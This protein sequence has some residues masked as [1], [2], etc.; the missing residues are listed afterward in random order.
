M[1]TL[2][3][4]GAGAD[5]LGEIFRRMGESGRTRQVLLVPEQISHECERA[6]CRILGN[7]ASA[8]CE[9]L[10]FTRLGRRV[11]DA[12]GGGAAKTLDAGGR[13]LLMYAALQKVAEELTVYRTPSRKPAFLSGLLETADECKSYA[14]TPDALCRAGEE[15]GGEEGAKCRDLGLIFGAYDAL[16]SRV[17]ADPRD[18]LDRL[19]E[20]LERSRWA[21]GRDFWIYGF[22]DFTPQE[23]GVLRRVLE[24]AASV[25]AALVCDGREDPSGVF[26]AARRS[27]AYLKRLCQQAGTD[28]E[29]QTL[30]PAAGREESL[31]YLEENLFASE[32]EPYAGPCAVTLVTAGDERSEAEWAAAEIL[33]L[34]R[35]EGYRFRDCAVARRPFDGSADLFESVFRKYGVPVFLNNV[36]DILQKP[37]LALVTGALDAAAG[38]YAY[39]D[40]FRYLKTGLTALAPEEC[41]KLENYVLTWDIRG[42]KWNREWTMH[43]EGYGKEFR[44]GDEEKLAELNSLREKVMAPLELL[45]KNETRTGRGDAMALY[46]FLEDIGLPDRL[47]GRTGELT[48][49][50][51]LK[52]AAEYSQLWDILCNALEQCALLLEDAPLDME[53]F[54]RLFSLV[55]SQYDVG[56]IPVSLDRVTAGDAA[57]MGGTRPKVLFFLGADSGNVPQA[58]AA[59][60]LLTDLDRELLSLQDLEL[61]PRLADKMNREMTILYEACS[62][63][64][65]RL[66]MSWAGGTGSQGEEKTP[67]FLVE[68][69]D[70]LF[71]EAERV[72]E[73]ALDGAYRL[74]APGPALEQ[75]GRYPEAA[76]ALGKLP[77]YAPRASRALGAREFRRGRLSPASVR[78]LFGEKVPMSAT[79]LDLY[80]SCHFSHFL[81]FGLGAKPREKARFQASD[82]G[83][84]VHAVLETVLRGASGEENGLR[85]LAED[86][87]AL[88]RA[89]EEAIDRYIA[90]SLQGLEDEGRRFRFLFERMR[91]NVRQVVGDAVDELS[92]SDFAPAAFELGFGRGRDCVLPPVE[93]EN[94]VTLQL[95]GFVDRVDAWVSG[96]R[97][98]LR[99]VDYKTGKKSF[100]F[101]DVKDGRGLQMLLYLF[102]LRERG[103]E[104]FG[105]EEIV[106]AGV[107]YFPARN[108]VV[109]GA[110]NMS[111]DKVK[112]E[113]A[114]ELRR[115]GLVLADDDVLEAM[116]HG[117]KKVY[118]PVSAGKTDGLVT[119]EQMDLLEKQVDKALFKAAGEMAGGTIAADPFW[120]DD[121]H[122]ACRWCDY[123]AACQFGDSRDDCKRPQ[124]GLSAGEYFTELEREEE[125]DHGV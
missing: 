101:A 6:M 93:A 7:S 82:Y 29:E 70:R 118:L 69:L 87:D 99:V 12:A 28:W 14:V 27:A 40:M 30:P 119:A 18:R 54:A 17:A 81:K 21:E 96:D 63:P 60:G 45:R 84:F 33:R 113:Q 89:T 115:K 11:A 24:Q 68:R 76:A 31:A 10:S 100:D 25:T 39:E 1:L 123:A 35:E 94:G 75:V 5:H 91:E 34:V 79:R 37:I 71:P 86:R 59:P 67:S 51:E 19:A 92:R 66:Y 109:S 38:D 41:D 16:T 98:Y 116:E 3:T 2:L 13:V 97:R 62:A 52:K 102:A 23:G 78:D 108:P 49:A 57:R 104:L 85:R 124:K 4:G 114:R 72:D 103:R 36:T 26:D 58:S 88:S 53:Q 32:S 117:E 77:E 74:A 15:I 105:P 50:G 110:R 125:R 42:N 22:T 107:L 106:P 55:L 47:D 61:A 121:E 64:T 56:T 48:A 90:E 43:P 44:E 112:S 120:R 46:R 20:K 111:A 73:R 80:N 122:N 83:T 8:R 65:R 95:G 9:V